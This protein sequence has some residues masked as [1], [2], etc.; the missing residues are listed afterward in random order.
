MFTKNNSV[1]PGRT[2]IKG[3]YRRSGDI[4]HFWLFIPLIDLFL[5]LIA[6]VFWVKDTNI[7]NIAAIF[8]VF[9]L[10]MFFFC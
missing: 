10:I 9:G 2:V 5:I 3:K 7:I 4:S 8:F 6:I 1:K